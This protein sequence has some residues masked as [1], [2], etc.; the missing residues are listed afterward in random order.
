MYPFDINNT[1][2]LL[3]Q[4]WLHKW[5]L[6]AILQQNEFYEFQRLLTNYYNVG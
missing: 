5:V 1:N 6:L 4:E 2:N 3:A